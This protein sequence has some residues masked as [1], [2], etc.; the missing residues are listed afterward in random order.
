MFVYQNWIYTLH[1]QYEIHFKT[2]WTS[3]M[4]FIVTINYNN[5]A[6]YDTKRAIKLKLILKLFPLK[7]G[8]VFLLDSANHK[9]TSNSTHNKNEN[10]SKNKG[11]T[12]VLL[13]APTVQFNQN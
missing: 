5:N 13:V 10:K 11:L 1:C 7:L 12:T 8:L 4:V 3:Y 9:N 2:L 6:A